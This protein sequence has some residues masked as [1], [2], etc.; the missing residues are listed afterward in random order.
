M[1]EATVWPVGKNN[2][3]LH[4]EDGHGAP[5]PEQRS[6]TYLSAQAGPIKV[7]KNS[8]HCCTTA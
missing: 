5:G 3:L 1:D 8:H 6:L 7:E 4:L 2:S